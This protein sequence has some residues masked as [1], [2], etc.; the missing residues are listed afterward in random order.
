MPRKPKPP[1]VF[2]MRIEG[3]SEPGKLKPEDTM[4]EDDLEP[5]K[6]H[7]LAPQII[8]RK[9][10][11]RERLITQAQWE[12]EQRAAHIRKGEELNKQSAK[13]AMD[14]L[15]RMIDPPPPFKRRF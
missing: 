12:N 7:S 2:D 13:A 6:M 10:N 15:R 3:L 4:F 1:P 5:G 14:A 9:V 11:A 8:E